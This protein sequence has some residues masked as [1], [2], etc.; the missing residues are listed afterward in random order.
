MAGPNRAVRNQARPGSAHYTL[1]TDYRPKEELLRDFEAANV[2]VEGVRDHPDGRGYS[3]TIRDRD[4][5]L[6][7]LWVSQQSAD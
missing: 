4:G 1:V 2:S 3:C 5:N 6:L 7:E